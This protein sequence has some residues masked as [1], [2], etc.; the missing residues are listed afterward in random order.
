MESVHHVSASSKILFGKVRKIVPP[1]LEKFHKGQL[2]RVAVIGGCADYTGAPYF[3]AIA[4]AKLG[5]D[6]SHVL[7]ERSA[8]PVIKSYSPNLMVHPLLP[9]TETVKDPKSIDASELAGPIISMLSRL[10]ALVIGPGLGRDG[11]TLKVVAEVIKEARARSIPF[12]LDADGLLIVTEDPNLIKGYKECILTPNVVEFGRLAKALGIKVASQA[13]IA[14]EGEGDTTNKESD[15]CEQLSEALGGVTILQKGPH[16]VISNG[17]TSIISDIKGGL[18]RSGGQGDT[19][20]GSLG[21]MLAWRSAYHNKLWES[22]EKD[23]E[24]EAQSRDEVQ[25]ELESEGKRM[26]PTTTLLLAAWAG[27]SITRECS[28]RAFEAKGRSMQA[29]DLT[30]EVHGSFL[31]LI[32]E[33]EG[34]KTHL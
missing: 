12:V 26:S 5:C 24:R 23:N 17:V 30:D 15:A 11:V 1:M 20:T 29:S 18:K 9:S 25:A 34:S 28:R 16:D 31:R 8:A 22:G 32:G 7:C 21:T 6:M 10:H 33:P 13:D 2:G 19:L 3:S 4:S 27:S 14:K